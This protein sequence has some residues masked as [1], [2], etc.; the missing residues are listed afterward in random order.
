MINFLIKW[1]A[2]EYIRENYEYYY[3]KSK[4]YMYRFQLKKK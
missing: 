4:K 1:L 2:Y 3:E